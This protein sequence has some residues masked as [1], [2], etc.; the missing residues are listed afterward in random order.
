[1]CFENGFGC[2]LQR[3]HSMNATDPEY[4]P[5]PCLRVHMVVAWQ[6]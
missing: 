4:V 6:I 3:T 1:M 5:A 2:L